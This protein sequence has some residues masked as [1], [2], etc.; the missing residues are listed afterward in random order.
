VQV[1]LAGCGSTVPALEHQSKT[2]VTPT[3]APVSGSTIEI[4]LG[5]RAVFT[6]K[7]KLRPKLRPVSN[8]SSSLPVCRHSSWIT[9]VLF[10]CR[11]ALNCLRGN[12]KLKTEVVSSPST[13]QGQSMPVTLQCFSGFKLNLET[14]GDHPAPLHLQVQVTSSLI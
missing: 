1:P 6:F 10:L 14:T 11:G 4:G 7:F 9:G 3:P 12:L 8:Y 13:T 5:S 2:L